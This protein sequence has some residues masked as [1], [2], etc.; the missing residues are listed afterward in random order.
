MNSAGEG[1]KL[2]WTG[3]W[4][5][6]Y[7]LLNLVINEKVLVRPHYLIDSTRASTQKE[8]ETMNRIKRTLKD[9]FPDS[10]SLI[11][12]VSY[13]SIDDIPNDPAITEAFHRIKARNYIG[14]QYDWLARYCKFFKLSELHLC[15]HEDDKAHLVI[16]EHLKSEQNRAIAP[17]VDPNCSDNDIF[18]VFRHFHFPILQLTKTQMQDLSEKAGFASL[19]EMTWF[20]HKPTKGKPC[21]ECNPCLYTAQ[22]GLGRRI[23]P[24]RR[25]QGSIKK[26]IRNFLRR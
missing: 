10:A 23:S 20:C 11:L 9:Q 7:Q 25:A 19:M 1:V 4:D 2:L 24:H 17:S 15:I 18:E 8:L 13:H 5:S 12:P 6:T 14:N 3:G 22:E 21:G 16:K 26:Y